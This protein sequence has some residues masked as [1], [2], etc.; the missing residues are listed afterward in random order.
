MV[1]DVPAGGVLQAGLSIEA[2][3]VVSIATGAAVPPPFDAVVPVEQSQRCD[4]SPGQVQFTAECAK[5]WQNIHRRASD[6]AAAD[7][8]LQGGLPLGPHHLGIAAAVGA[9]ELSV[10]RQPHVTILTTGDEVRE[11]DTPTSE[12]APQQI[13]SSNGPML[14]ALVEQW[15]AKVVASLHVPD[16]PQATLAAAHDAL[17]ISDLVLTTGGVS[18][19]QRDLLPET[20]RKLGLDVLVHG[21]AIQPGKPVFVARRPEEHR[22]KDASGGEVSPMVVGLPGNPV[23]VLAT[24]HLF[25]QPILRVMQSLPAALPWRRVWLAGEARA[26]DKRQ[27]FRAVRYVGQTREQVQIIPWQGSG[28]LMHTALADGFVRLPIQAE[29]VHPGEPLAMLPLAGTRG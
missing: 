16:E 25:V 17:A 8:V 15:G 4:D 7:V 1:S 27:V 26:S 23:S 28:D 6:A 21:V 3:D 20:W 2:G 29:P 5:P 19:G 14:T 10:T 18:V 22:H 24:A 12:L 13:R 9:A 11:P